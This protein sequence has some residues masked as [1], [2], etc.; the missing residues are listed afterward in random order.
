M[1]KYIFYN[2][3]LVQRFQ[4]FSLKSNFMTT[5][6]IGRIY[7]KNSDFHFLL[8]TGISVHLTQ[9][10]TMVTTGRSWAAAGILQFSA[11]TSFAMALYFQVQ[12]FNQLPRL[13]K[14]LSIKLLISMVWCNID[15]NSGCFKKP[16]ITYGCRS[17]PRFIDNRII[18]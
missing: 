14:H 9:M 5:L 6:K 3:S 1:I 7:N 8:K 11:V 15:K 16:L 18:C 10:H 2:K 4:I 13:S 17:Q 12:I